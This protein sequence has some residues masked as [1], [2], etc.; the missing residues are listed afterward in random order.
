MTLTT[1]LLINPYRVQLHIWLETAIEC[2]YDL[3]V[4]MEMREDLIV[5]L[6]KF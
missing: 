1:K 5:E 3:L 6:S 2:V 4:D